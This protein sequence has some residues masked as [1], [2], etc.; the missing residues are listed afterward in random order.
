MPNILLCCSGSVATIKVL[1][2]RFRRKL[3]RELHPQSRCLSLWRGSVLRKVTGWFRTH[4]IVELPSVVQYPP[5]GHWELAP[6][7]ALSLNSWCWG[8]GGLRG[9]PRV[10]EMERPRGPGPSH[11]AQKMGGPCPRGAL[12]CQHLGQVGQWHGWQSLVVHP[13]VGAICY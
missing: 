6:L 9:R 8:W 11:R 5:C 3:E 12:L 10:G 4:V 2:H 1:I 7:L 13:E